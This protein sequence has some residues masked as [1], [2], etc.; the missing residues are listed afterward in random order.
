[1]IEF[2]VIVGI[3]ILLAPFGR[4]GKYKNIERQQAMRRSMKKLQ[5]KYRHHH[6]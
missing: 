6:L 4:V 5:E 1:M 2:L 3:I